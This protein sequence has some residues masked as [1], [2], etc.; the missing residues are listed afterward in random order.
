MVEKIKIPLLFI[1]FS[2]LLPVF[3]VE[4]G[5]LTCWDVDGMSIFGYKYGEYIYIGSIANEFDSKSIANEFGWGNEFKSNSIMNEFGN[6]GSEFSSYSAFNEFATKPPIIINRNNEF[7]GYLTINDFKTPCINT[8]SAIMCAGKSF[9]SPIRGHEDIVFKDIP[10]KSGGYGGYDYPNLEEL[11]KDSCPPN[12]TYLNGICVCNSGYTYYND[13][14]ITYTARC[15]I[16][17][18]YN[19][20][21]VKDGDKTQCYCKGGYGWNSD[22]TACIRSIVCPQNSTKIGNECFC[23]EGYIMRDGDCITHTEDCIREYGSNVYGLRRDS[24]NSSCYCKEEYEWNISRTACIKS[25]VCPPNSSKIA[26]ECVCNDDYEWDSSGRVCIEKVEEKISLVEEK[27]YSQ[28][29]EETEKRVSLQLEEEQGEELE[30][31]EQKP[32]QKQKKS[33]LASVSAFAASIFD[34]VKDFFYRIFH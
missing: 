2:L 14:C 4:A 13:I 28:K 12:S 11:L 16:S 30:F 19:V 31:K 27:Q 34:A 17:Y 24:G 18:G 21:G 33:L 22:E 32:E 10:K 20:Y 26:G 3:Y 5:N 15:E 7:V 23:N 25:I 8:Y 1:S 6:F 9:M 29:K